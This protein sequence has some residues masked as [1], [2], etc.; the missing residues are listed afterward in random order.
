MV[1]EMD[2]SCTDGVYVGTV[3]G[4]VL[5]TSGNPPSATT[6]SVCSSA[7][8]PGKLASDGTFSLVANFCFESTG[9]YPVPVFIYHG[10]PDYANVVVNFVAPNT[11]RLDDV[12][13]AQT[14][15]TVALAGLTRVPYDETQAFSLSD[16]KGFSLTTSAPKAIKMP[17]GQNVVAAGSVDLAYFPL[18][19]DAGGESLSALYVVAPTGAEVAPPAT[20]RFPNTT[21][22]EAGAPVEV[23]AIGDI[24]TAKAFAPGTLGVIGTGRVTPDGKFIESVP[25]TDTGI[26]MIGWLGYRP[27]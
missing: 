23:L 20:I 10:E 27:K 14:I 2:T 4:K 7:C 5:D 21:N 16:G 13:L 9:F 3:R 25:G 17:F 8:V 19:K 22:L 24:P 1:D 12:T 11:K 15:H 6:I 26:G 18:G